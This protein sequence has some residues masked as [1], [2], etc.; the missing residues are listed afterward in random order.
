M[1]RLLIAFL[2]LTNTV[3]GQTTTKQNVEEKKLSD[4]I[5]FDQPAYSIQYP[6]KWE[7]NNSGEMGTS[8][9]LFSPLESVTDQFKENVN[10]LIQDLSGY[11]IDINKYTEISVGQIKTMITNA[12]LLESK[13]V[14]KNTGE[15]HKLI[16]TGDQGSFHLKFEQY[17][18][19]IKDKAYVLTLT[20]EID[21][22]DQYAEVGEEILNSFKLK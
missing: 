16:Y 1:K 22:F 7:L 4:W 12:T 8:C 6:S 17:Y 3:Y 20:S 10:L 13:R 19:V 11:N 9:V 2:L 15:Y 18:F 14:K 21:K 5:T